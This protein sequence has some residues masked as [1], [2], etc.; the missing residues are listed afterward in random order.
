MKNKNF[1]YLTMTVIIILC[2]GFAPKVFQNDTFYTIKIGELILNNGVDMLDHF[3]WH[4][5]A[6]TYPH[7]LYDV[8]IYSI[9]AVSG[10][11]GLYI[12][13]IILF[14]ILISSIYYVNSKVNKNIVMAFFISI[15]SLIVLANFATARAQLVSF[16]LFIWEFYFIE[17]LLKKKNKKYIIGLFIVSLLLCNIHVAVWPF[18]FVMF[19]PY[20]AE[21]LIS[22]I[23][24]KMK[25]RK[26][27]K[28]KEKDKNNKILSFISS[29][30]SL[31]KNDNVKYLIII[32]LLCTLTGLLTPIGDTP[33]TYFY[34]T[35]IGNS[36]DYI[37]EHAT[38]PLLKSPF[39][40]IILLETFLLA[41]LSKIKLRDLFMISGL[42]IMA[43][44]SYRHMSL[45][46]LIGGACFIRL[47]IECLNK[48][49]IN[50]NDGFIKIITKKWIAIS[51]ISVALI[52]SGILLYTK[53]D[54][55]YIDTELYPVE[56]TEYI[57][58]NLDIDKIRLYNEYNFGSY[59]ILQNIPVFID[60]RA[61]LYTKPFSGL[62]YD[63][64]DDY[65][66]II[67]NYEEKLEFYDITH[68]L[69]FQENG[70][71]KTLKT[72]PKYEILYEDDN[73]II[74]ERMIENED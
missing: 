31:E 43:I 29:K 49:N 13:S 64:F 56:A 36:Q 59:L 30:I 71:S 65:Q 44:D 25:N 28:K 68:L 41:L 2:I 54:K 9:Y 16:I 27:K 20:I 66:F 63:I 26:K 67:S 37:L 24:L 53:Y 18:F 1:L 72:H 21:Y 45:F 5:L 33:Y 62:D 6:Y 23:L 7:W 47:F 15:I 60:S 17:S 69:L 42:A 34:K 14:I 10:F 32:M 48:S 50:L 58:E 3:S 73:F 46:V 39:V 70:L 35:F 55:S 57:K 11:T 19:L 4:D 61:D 51:L 38:T 52:L 8:F 12:S 74:F 22:I 40:L